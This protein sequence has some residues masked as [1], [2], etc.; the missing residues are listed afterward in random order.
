[1]LLASVALCGLIAGCSSDGASGDTALPFTTL[2]DTTLPDTTLPFTTRPDT[3]LPFTTLPDTTLPDTTGA[4][5]GVQWETVAAPVDCMCSDGSGVQFYVHRADP[6][7]VV[8]FFEGGGAC[9]S[10]ATCGSGATFQPNA[11]YGP[12]FETTGEGIF[13]FSDTRN[14]FAGW[15]FVYVPYC[16]GDVFLGNA[17]H[18]YGEG[19][20]IQ[21]KGF[22]NASA[23]LDSL[24][25]RF[26]DAAQLVVT[27]E[28]AGGVPTPM[29]GGLAHDLLP[30]AAITV[31]AD[32]S[33]AYPDVPGINSLVGSLWGTM[34]AVP[35]WPENAGMTVDR[36]SIPGLFVQAG[37]HDPAIVFARHDYASDVVQTFFGSLVG[38]GA[39]NLV[40]LIDQNETEI[41]SNGVNVLGFV[42]PGIGHTVLGSPEFYTEAVNG[43]Q[44]VDWVAGLLDRTTTNDVHCTDCGGS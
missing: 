17:T 7:K 21:H 33:G 41:E 23:A 3:T 38:F 22:V 8:L 6:A 27:G 40:T 16:T 19:I 13:D 43:V 42:A 36:W 26:P 25:Q 15:S 14:P 9:F 18:D 12:A 32:S 20:V 4:S 35:D 24:A 30:A 5:G 39:D 34:N 37:K 1:M 10:A 29:F 44:F 11:D 28:S 2:P 31:L